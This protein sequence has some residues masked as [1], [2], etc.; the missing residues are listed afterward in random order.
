MKKKLKSHTKTINLKYQLRREM[1][2]LS[3]LAD[4]ILHQIF[5][6]TLNTSLKNMEKRL[7]ILQ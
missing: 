1:K 4:H 7:I 3:Y 2:N 6:I 5:K